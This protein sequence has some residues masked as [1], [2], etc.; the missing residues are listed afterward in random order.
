MSEP[1]HRY[2]IA[3]GGN[4]RHVRHGA[5][6]RVLA[7]AMDGLVRGPTQVMARSRIMQSPPVG[8]SRRTYANAAVLVATDLDPPEMLDNLK[9]LEHRFDRATG[10]QR[11]S[12]RT[13][14]CDIVL[15][16]GGAWCDADLTIPHPEY[17]RRDFVL[18]PALDVA[19]DWRDPLGGL[20]I[21]Q[22]LFRL[23]R[24]GA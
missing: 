4:V 15:W 24:Q 20:T 19:P 11:W 5:P 7:A 1:A 21:R 22:L 6:A 8:P 23:R 3:L 16:S 18:I 10:G 17:R 12:A 9:S 14:D 13:L 2:L